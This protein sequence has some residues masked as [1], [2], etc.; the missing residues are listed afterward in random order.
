MNQRPHVLIAGCGYVGSAL[1]ARLLADGRSVFTLRRG[2]QQLPGCV[3]LRADL[4][5][6]AELSSALCALPAGEALEVCY[7][8][9]AGGFTPAL[10]RAAY[11]DGPR[12]LLNAL[13][14]R[15]VRRVVYASS[16]AVYGDAAGGWVDE[17][18]PTRPNAFS[19]EIL[20]Q[21]ERWVSGAASSHCIL[22]FGGIYGPGRTTLIERLRRGEAIV[23]AAG[24]RHRNRIHREDCAAITQ[25]VLDMPAP[26]A[27]YNAVDDEPAPLV[28]VQQWLCRQLQ[29]DPASLRAG[30][31]RTRRP[32]SD[33]RCTNR[34]L[35]GSGYQLL[36]PHYRAGYAS[37]LAA[38]V[39]ASS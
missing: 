29:I 26:R 12:N 3:A 38:S 18:M 24:P 31:R 39:P 36:F 11:L 1:A 19:G 34:R 23:Q 32:P 10:Y 6:V 30:N 7:M 17:T 33:K 9:A 25:H 21:G 4:G 28:E 13:A 2:E 27:V 16:T 22:R 5:D 35:H 8:A 20:L 14:T 15:E 37:L